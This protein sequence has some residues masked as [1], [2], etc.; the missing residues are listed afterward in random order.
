MISQCPN[1]KTRFVVGETKLNIAG[2]SVR[3][4][5]CM[6]VFSATD[7]RQ[8]SADTPK[9]EKP[10]TISNKDITEEPL[11]NS[12][13]ASDDS[14]HTTN[15]SDKNAL[16]ETDEGI[17]QNDESIEP[18]I[19]SIASFEV[20]PTIVAPPI[21]MLISEKP[22]L[23]NRLFGFVGVSFCLA[24]I[25]VLGLHWLL[26][27]PEQFKDHPR[28]RTTYQLACQ[29]TSPLISCDLTDSK[30]TDQTQL[31]SVTSNR[32]I[33]HPEQKNTLLLETVILNTAERPLPFPVINVQFSDIK[34]QQL[35]EFNFTAADY[36]RGELENAEHIPPAT[37]IHI[38]LKIS[39]PG[40]VA[41][42]YTVKLR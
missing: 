37:P 18:S 1:C 25:F 12:L 4:G 6:Q 40:P 26:A 11:N 30:N 22:T 38:A 14:G 35:D 28:W 23:K 16:K 3:C 21:E 5:A 42:N 8:T 34:E 15:L 9:V 19:E 20:P 17:P 7:H 36:L 29:L 33:S 2:G 24:L 27:H 10:T 32:M 13:L 39:D 31:L 41:V